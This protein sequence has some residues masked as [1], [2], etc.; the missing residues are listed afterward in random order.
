MKKSWKETK[1]Y[2][3]FIVTFFYYVEYC[4]EARVK[5]NLCYLSCIRLSSE[6]TN[7][8]FFFRKDL[9]SIMRA[10][11]VMGYH[12]L[13]LPWLKVSPVEPFPDAG[14]VAEVGVRTVVRV[15]DHVCK[16]FRRFSINY[17]ADFTTLQKMYNKFVHE[18]TNFNFVVF[19]TKKKLLP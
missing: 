17:L 1:L 14:G 8:I 15:V 4:I 7:R 3:L 16:T 13:Y 18:K 2:Y 9:F 19:R 11:Y 10:Q 12:L 5:R 6:G